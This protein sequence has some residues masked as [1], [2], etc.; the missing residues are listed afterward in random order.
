[1]GQTNKPVTIFFSYV[2]QDAQLRTKL[3]AQLLPL[4]RAGSI[5]SWHDY[6]IL[7]GHP[8]SSEINRHLQEADLILLLISPDYISS[9]DHYDSE[10]LKALARH[11]KGEACVIP[12]L[13]RPTLLT[14]TPF[15]ELQALPRNK[16]PVTLWTDQDE[17][18]Y[19]IA[20]DISRVVKALAAEKPPEA[21]KGLW[22]GPEPEPR[23]KHSKR[24]VVPLVLLCL[25]L[26]LGTSSGIWFLVSQHAANNPHGLLSRVSSTKTQPAVAPTQRTQQPSTKTAADASPTAGRQPPAPGAS[27]TAG[28]QPVSS[29]SVLLANAEAISPVYQDALNNQANTN[30]QQEGW[31]TASSNPA[32]GAACAFTSDGYEVNLSNGDTGLANPSFCQAKQPAPANTLIEVTMNIS[33]GTAGLLFR[34]QYPNSWGYYVF[35]LYPTT[36]RYA[37]YLDASNNYAPLNGLDWRQIPANVPATG[38]IYTL[39]VLAQGNHLYFYINKTY[40]TDTKDTTYSS[41]GIG[42]VCYNAPGSKSG[43]ALF[44]AVSLRDLTK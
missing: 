11:Q 38:N 4:Q 32:V 20:A 34:D 23:G 22:D 21:I 17:A 3:D 41:G 40:V 33:S 42:F 16:V 25:L 5:A 37:I 31:D 27:P 26:L 15:K 39:Q 14:G 6:H 12:V 1:M 13:L 8:R 2:E 29:P 19:T 36:D 9:G 44:T 7:A 18:F 24:V 28:G 10:M 43:Q 35:I 30:T